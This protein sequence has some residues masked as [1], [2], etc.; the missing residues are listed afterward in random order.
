[1]AE[2]GPA[3]SPLEL[4]VESVLAGAQAALRDG[5]DRAREDDP[6][7]DR[8]EQLAAWLHQCSGGP[9]D[10]SGPG[11]ALAQPAGPA[12]PA[13]PPAPSADEFTL[14]FAAVLDQFA[15]DDRVRQQLGGPPA[16]CTAPGAAAAWRAFW[17]ACLRLDA[18]LAAR[19][20]G[21]GRDAA[22][23]AMAVGE[24]GWTEL[25]AGPGTP[26]RVLVPPAPAL[27]V[28]GIRER[29]GAAADPGLGDVTGVPDA[30]SLVQRV[31]ALLEL[32]H[33]LCHALEGLQVTGIHTLN[34]P[35][36]AAEFRRELL[37]RLRDAT[38]PDVGRLGRLLGLYQLDE[39][40]C[41]AVHQPPAHPE[42]WWG[43][44]ATASHR[45]LRQAAQAAAQD[46]VPAEV[47]PLEL[48]PYADLRRYTAGR[49]VAY[50]VPRDQVGIVLACLRTWL[51]A[52]G[53]VY[54]GRVI[55]G[56]E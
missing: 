8:A 5:L 34:D 37:R 49:N 46:G 16:A 18:Q 26:V 51:E 29:P 20:R 33:E 55:W 22:V 13:G 25:P 31:L 45:L 11:P 42:S 3:R 23:L 7:R 30:A 14:A 40:I 53:Q 2:P 54:P 24:P 4:L 39:A 52:D 27:G 1:M 35:A 32:D 50:R 10:L 38:R 36:T 47:R 15:A 44:L 43:D 21:A 17:L 9:P 19:W 48:L 28:A 6:G 56:S 41:S 12:A